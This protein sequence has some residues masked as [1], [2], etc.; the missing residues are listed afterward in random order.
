MCVAVHMFCFVYVYACMWRG[1]MYYFHPP[2]VFFSTSTTHFCLRVFAYFSV[3]DTYTAQ[4]TLIGVQ[5]GCEKRAQVCVDGFRFDLCQDIKFCFHGVDECDA[6]TPFSRHV[7]HFSTPTTRA[8][9]IYH[10]HSLSDVRCMVVTWKNGRVRTLWSNQV[11]YCIVFDVVL[12]VCCSWWWW[13]CILRII[14]PLLW[15]TLEVSY[16]LIQ[17]IFTFLASYSA[18]LDDCAHQHLA[19]QRVAAGSAMTRCF[20]ALVCQ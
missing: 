3:F 16:A 4:Y 13:Y 10:T 17:C 1:L 8:R 7:G 5:T 19:L 18:W 9:H 12:I 15:C 11:C 6:F 2:H 14:M 20:N